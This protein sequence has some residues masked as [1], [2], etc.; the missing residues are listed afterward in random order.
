MTKNEM[1]IVKLQSMC[2]KKPLK[3]T[4]MLKL[5]RCI[6]IH[7][8]PEELEKDEIK[9]DYKDIIEVHITNGIDMGCK[10][11]TIHTHG[12]Q[13]MELMSPIFIKTDFG[14]QVTPA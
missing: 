7:L 11:N 14:G 8:C 10:E 12:I 13:E 9:E 4:Y 5:W 3:F 1:K 6:G 2:F